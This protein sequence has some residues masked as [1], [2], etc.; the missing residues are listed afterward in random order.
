MK[1]H[2]IG[3]LSKRRHFPFTEETPHPDDVEVWGLNAIRPAWVPRW[4]RMFNLHLYENLVRYKWDHLSDE[5]EWSMENPDVPFLTLDKW[6]QEHAL[7]GWREFPGKE[8]M[9]FQ[10]RGTYH[11]SSFDWMVAY[12]MWLNQEVEGQGGPGRIK[13]PVDE[14]MLHGCQLTM[15][16]G[17][18][19][20]ARVC[21]EYWCGRA[22][23]EGIKITLAEDAKL[24]D[25][26]HLVRSDLIY[27]YDDT[28]VVEDSTRW[29]VMTRLADKPAPYDYEK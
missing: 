10:N 8:M 24:F 12:A 28:P 19:I 7:L 22:E 25:F 2:M 4:H 6:P 27:G 1:I 26:Y 5:S 13:R 21:L 20:S 15:E 11:V 14:I 9:S 3:G 29:E 17:E 16:A 18:P 23:G